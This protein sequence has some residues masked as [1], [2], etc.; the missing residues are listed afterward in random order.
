MSC[1][2]VLVVPVL[3]LAR[4]LLWEFFQRESSFVEKQDLS[5]LLEMLI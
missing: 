3:G 4:I 1:Q 2:I 5:I